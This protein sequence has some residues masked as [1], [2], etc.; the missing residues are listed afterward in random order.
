MAD[1]ET[2]MALL[3]DAVYHLLERGT[4]IELVGDGETPEFEIEGEAVS[5]SQV[6]LK[7]YAAGMAEAVSPGA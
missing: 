4:Q 5:S 1:A 7:A 6:I 2:D 3:K